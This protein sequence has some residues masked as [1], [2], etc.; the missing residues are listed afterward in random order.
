MRKLFDL[1]DRCAWKRIPYTASQFKANTLLIS[2]KDTA[3]KNQ[4]N[5]QHLN[6]KHTNRNSEDFESAMQK[7]DAYK[8]AKE[9]NAS[10][11]DVRSGYVFSLFAY[12]SHRHSYTSRST[13]TEIQT[14]Y[15]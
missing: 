1:D 3:K 2:N 7:T 9:F 4:E 12:K 15:K 5:R 14:H 11:D 13:Q 8:G 10:S 6:I